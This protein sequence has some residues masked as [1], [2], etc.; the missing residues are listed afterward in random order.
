MKEMDNN[1]K[2]LN[3]S[4]L[5]EVTGGIAEPANKEK[6][7]EVDPNTDFKI[8]TCMRCKKKFKFPIFSNRKEDSS[9]AARF[10][11]KYPK[12]I[13][14]LEKGENY[15]CAKCSERLYPSRYW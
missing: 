15:L 9:P 2:E 5:M 1:N 8:F 13:K 14:E 7:S 6:N 4:R 3:E 12:L 11:A 10:W